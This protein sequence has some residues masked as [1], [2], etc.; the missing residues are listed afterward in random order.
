MKLKP[1]NTAITL[2][3][4]T[5]AGEMY[6][7]YNTKSL[8]PDNGIAARGLVTVRTDNKYK[9][10]MRTAEQPL[11]FQDPS[12]TFNAQSAG[13]T[14][15]EKELEV[16]PYEVHVQTDME[17]LRTTWESEKLGAGS[18][19]D[20]LGTTELSNF[21]MNSIYQP[22]LARMNEQLYMLGKSG[23]DIK[24]GSATFSATYDGLLAKLEAGSDVI[25]FSLSG[26]DSAVRTITAIT[27]GAA[28]AATVTVDS[29]TGVKVGD[30]ITIIGADGD[31]QIG[32]VTINGQTVQVLQV[33][34][35]TVL[36]INKAVTGSTAATTGTIQFVNQANVL[37]VL[38]YNYA[39][40]PETERRKGDSKM[41]VSTAIEK[42]Y[43]QANANVATG[44]GSYTRDAYFGLDNIPFLD[45][46]LEAMDYWK[47]NTIAFWNKDNVF[48]DV[49]LLSDDV[50]IKISYLGDLT[51]DEVYRMRNRMKSN[52]D[53]L[54]GEQILYTR[55]A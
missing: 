15:G 27:N 47:P 29:T 49:D 10:K 34:S 16:V 55:P 26:V 41:L 18:F 4:N 51:M 39:L 35:A 8:L 28:T 54:Y 37:D 31:Q 24:G 13:I 7:E 9:K 40:I 25:K 3:T 21:L 43:R 5:Y 19:A 38:N 17:K 12:A 42:A 2:S 36:R 30:N 52:I 20:Y 53:Y 45:I 33:V 46:T 6:P 22:Q 23:V 11:E 44:N 50:N 14:L 1:K 48:L 32:G